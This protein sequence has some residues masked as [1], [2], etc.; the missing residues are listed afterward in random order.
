[1]SL[2]LIKLLISAVTIV[3]VSELGKRVSWLAALVASL[4]L[5]SLLALIWLYIDTKNP[6]KVIALSKG[7][8]WAV[9]PSLTFFVVFPILMK[10]SHSFWFSL[11]V[12]VA[13]MFVGYLAYIAILKQ[14]G[15]RF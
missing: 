6:E 3:I 5:T 8:F 14:F 12:S 11:I 13:I 1:M 15:I 10:W 7:V 2:Y 4:P 9:L